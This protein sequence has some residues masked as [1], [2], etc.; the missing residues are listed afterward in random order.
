MNAVYNLKENQLVYLMKFFSSKH[1]TFTKEHETLVGKTGTF[2]KYLGYRNRQMLISVDGVPYVWRTESVKPITKVTTNPKEHE[3]ETV[4][5]GLAIV[6]SVS[7]KKDNLIM[8][9]SIEQIEKLKSDQLHGEIEVGEVTQ[10]PGELSEGM[11]K[12]CLSV[13]MDKSPYLSPTQPTSTL[14]AKNPIECGVVEGNNGPSKEIWSSFVS[15]E[16]AKQTAEQIQVPLINL[17]VAKAILKN[18]N[19][20]LKDLSKQVVDSTEFPKFASQS[21]DPVEILVDL[22][23]ICKEVNFLA[24]FVDN[25]VKSYIS[26]ER[27]TSGH[28]II[29]VNRLVS[30][31]RHLFTFQDYNVALKFAKVYSEQLKIVSSTLFN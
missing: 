23:R 5:G 22:K 26:F 7:I 15:E 17:E 30:N 28:N 3:F 25:P 6:P 21:T 4:V 18:P 1:L 24:P 27:N 20:F 31:D 10:L 8:Y 12:V 14:V 13:P 9:G 19:Q 29:V 11:G 16:M 2:I